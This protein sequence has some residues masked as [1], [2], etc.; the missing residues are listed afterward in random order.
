MAQSQISCDA[1]AMG[2]TRV[3]RINFETDLTILHPSEGL[4]RHLRLVANFLGIA[5]PVAVPNFELKIVRLLARFFTHFG[6]PRHNLRCPPI[7]RGR[8]PN[9]LRLVARFCVGLQ[10]QVEI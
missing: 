9:N 10:I 1:S 3:I 8:L 4:T 7:N 5:T 6:H 2:K